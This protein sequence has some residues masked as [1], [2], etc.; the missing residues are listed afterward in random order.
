MSD[1][2]DFFRDYP[3]PVA[4]TAQALRSA[5]LAALPGAVET[6]DR[7]DRVVGYGF[8]PGYA[9][10]ICTII[11]SRTGVKLGISNS[12]T[13]PDPAGLLEGSGKRHKYVAIT[14]PAGAKRAALKTLIKSAHAAWKARQR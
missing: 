5:I 7:P 4:E 1:A 8:G 13:L 6:V 11:P 3:A 2:D 9:G 10:L 12:A 14:D